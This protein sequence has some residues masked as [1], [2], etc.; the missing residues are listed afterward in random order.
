MT[1]TE[2]DYFALDVRIGRKDIL[3]YSVKVDKLNCTIWYSHTDNG[4]QLAPVVRP[5]YL[6]NIHT[7][8]RY[9]QLLRSERF[10]DFKTSFDWLT[11]ELRLINEF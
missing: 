8:G 4:D 2:F 3:L 6:V 7:L 1:Y 9:P 11:D 10:G 5:P